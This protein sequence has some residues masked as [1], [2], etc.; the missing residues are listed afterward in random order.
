MNVLDHGDLSLSSETAYIGPGSSARLLNR[1][2]TSMISWHLSNELTIPERLLPVE[3]SPSIDAQQPSF[4]I[5]QDQRRFE[6]QSL[7]TPATQ[8]TIIEHYVKII[9][10]EYTLLP[11]ERDTA[12]LVHENPL[13][14]GNSNKTHPDALALSIV[15]AV[16]TTLITRDLD[17]NLSSMS[18]RCQEDV[19]RIPQAVV[20]LEDSIEKMRWTCTALCALA[21]CEM[22]SQASGQLWD[23]LGRAISTLE[24]LREGYQQRSMEVDSNFLRLERALLKLER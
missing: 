10:P 7:V 17:S 12:T 16:S 21:L 11:A 3:T 22:I 19:Q 24:D 20:S 6:L 14:W 9:S 4:P 2:A 8:R 5:V 1:L 13:R 15:F 23:L 18:M